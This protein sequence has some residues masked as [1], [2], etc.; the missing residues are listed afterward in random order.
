M[1][2]PTLASFTS[3]AIICTISSRTS[4]L[5]PGNW[6]DA[7]IVICACADADSRIAAAAVAKDV[8]I[9]LIMFLHV[10]FFSGGNPAAFG[11]LNYNQNP[12]VAP[13]LTLAAGALG[14]HGLSIKFGRNR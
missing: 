10:V 2:M 4:P 14:R 6:C 1:S 3:F 9:I 7:F 11:W 13:D 5:P 8:E 12:L